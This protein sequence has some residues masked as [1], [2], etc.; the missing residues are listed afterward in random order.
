MFQKVDP[1]QNFPNLEEEILEFWEKEKIFEKS[2][3]NRQGK[4]D[5][6]FYE[7]PPGTNGTPGLH[8]VLARIFKDIICRYKTM[9][10]FR[11][12]RRAGWDTHGLPV[13]L[14]VEKA[15]GISGKKEIEKYG[16]ENFN[17]K[18]RESAWKYKKDWEELTSRIGF[19]LDMEN[20]YI[21]YEAGYIESLWKIIK[22]IYDRELLYEDYK[23]VPYCPRCGT[24]LSAH[25]VAQGYKKITENSI[26][27]KLK[28]K[29]KENTYFLVWTT[30]PWTLPGN[31][32]LAIDK[33][34]EYVLVEDGGE[35]LILAKNRLEILKN[36][37]A[38]IIETY[39]GVQLIGLS[40]EPPYNFIDYHS[41][42]VYKVY[43]ANFVKANEGTGIVHTAVVYG[44]DDFEL[45]KEVD[46]PKV[47]SVDLS[48]RFVDEVKP[49]ANQEVKKSEP[50][51]VEE[52]ESRGLLYKEEKIEHDYPFCWRCDSALLYYAKNSWFIKVTA[53]KDKMIEE[54][55]KINWIPK[56]LKNGRFGN[57]LEEVKDWVFSRD[58]YWGTPLPIWKCEK[59]QKIKVIGSFKELGVDK[60]FDPHR[61]FVDGIVLDCF[62]GGKM[63]R[64]DEVADVW[65]DSGAMPFAS[66]EFE[67]NRY[68][69]DYIAEAVDQTRG[70]FYTLLAVS[71]LMEE[72]TSYKNVISLGHILDEKGQKMSK[73]KGNIIAPQE[74]I[75]KFGVDAL[76]WYFFTVSQPGQ[77]K[78]FSFVDLQNSFRKT[79][80]ILWNVY[81]FF[82]T[83]ANVDGFN[84]EKLKTSNDSENILD[85]W[86][87]SK[88]E[89]LI[90][91]VS[92]QFDIYQ[93][94]TAARSISNFVDELSTFYLRTSRKRRDENFYKTLYRVLIKLSQIIS[95]FCPFF[96]ESIYQN[97]T[98]ESS[99]HLSNWPNSESNKI[100]QDLI[101]EI[102]KIQTIITLALSQRAASGIKLR[103]PLGEC[104]I[105]NFQLKNEELVDIL[106]DE[107]NVKEVSLISGSGEIEVKL[108]L[109]ISA[110]LKEEGMVRDLIRFIQDLRKEAGFNISDK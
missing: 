30:T 95:P 77:A 92:Q 32:A 91:K 69:A 57:W 38:K 28:I 90:S 104:R 86:I 58:R 16:I 83:Y 41:D 10:G 35:K 99:V 52:L 56:Y 46:L 15:L 25:E 103:Q 18:C 29:E 85:Q 11:V 105:K 1:K 23:V 102:E 4:E 14:E 66:G 62:C 36:K 78:R 94:V 54:N 27:L 93:I 12:K 88:L 33:N 8:H 75:S 49:W 64:V 2:I 5:F 74:A 76:R 109:S 48:G 81:S 40:Y 19:W 101:S 9:Q 59:C 44:E 84:L 106:K 100:N 71:V 79:Q 82:I 87:L 98:E 67:Q 39:Q 43:G 70:W 20:P 26:Y 7:G 110:Q 63:K 96:S 21:T 45:G 68:P 34:L 6:I 61:P 42:K 53:V 51:I 55:Q 97:L 107:I 13:E 108:D 89:E 37:N 50:L 24:S 17:K 3:E 31:V 65:F 73:S 72:G 47:H 80:L 22:H 60:D